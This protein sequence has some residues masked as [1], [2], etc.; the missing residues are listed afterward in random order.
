[1]RSSRL[2]TR[3]PGRGCDRRRWCAARGGLRRV[4]GSSRR[5]TKPSGLM[6]LKTDERG[7]RLSD[8][9]CDLRPGRC[10]NPL[11]RL[12]AD[13]Q[14][15]RERS[16]DPAVAERPHTGAAQSALAERLQLVSLAPASVECRSGWPDRGP[17]VAA[18]VSLRPRPNASRSTSGGCRSQTCGFNG[19]YARWRGRT[20]LL[21]VDGE[22][23]SFELLDA[24]DK[25][26]SYPV[27]SGPSEG[28]PHPEGDG[29]CGSPSPAPSR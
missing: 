23:R 24:R 9:A 16:A 1:M 12:A 21:T 17:P 4:S 22:G 25:F 8:E 27:A 29:C 18:T 6:A 3:Q 14:P 11:G 7:G 5:G 28:I 15:G 10:R 19:P 13:C 26:D 20:G 2:T